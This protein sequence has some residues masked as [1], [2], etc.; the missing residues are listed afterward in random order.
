MDSK[1]RFSTKPDE[2]MDATSCL[3]CLGPETRT[4][5]LDPFI[6]NRSPVNKKNS[7]FNS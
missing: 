4:P 5:T 2:Q 3:I 7:D 1:C 6:S